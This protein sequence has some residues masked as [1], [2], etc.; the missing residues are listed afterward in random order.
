MNLNPTLFFDGINDRLTLSVTIPSQNTYSVFAIGFVNSSNSVSDMIIAG[1]DGSA[2]FRFDGTGTS[3]GKITLTKT[4]VIDIIQANITSGKQTLGTFL[5]NNSKSEVFTDAILRGTGGLINPTS[6]IDTIGN[7]S[8]T[9]GQSYL[10]NMQE[11]VLYTT[12]QSS[13]RT[14][15]ETNINSF[16]SIY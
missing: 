16:Y 11:I 1:R 5:S 3:N 14:G 7:E 9:F 8:S 2:G 6:V 4:N 15:I 12:D 13:T 10:G